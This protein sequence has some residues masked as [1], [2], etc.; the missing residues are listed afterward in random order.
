M[1]DNKALVKFTKKIP[2]V[3]VVSQDSPQIPHG[4]PGKKSETKGL[5]YDWAYEMAN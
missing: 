4:L 5:R 2:E 3:L 1:N